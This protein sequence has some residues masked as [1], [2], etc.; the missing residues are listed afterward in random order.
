MKILNNAPSSTSPLP[1]DSGSKC[2]S[3]SP[4]NAPA[5]KETSNRRILFKTFS[6]RNK[7]KTPTKEIK[8]ITSVDMI[9]A[10]K[11][12]MTS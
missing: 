6:F 10:T 12:D 5:E 1:I 2:K 4:I 11:I 9:I 3:A 8:L 7:I